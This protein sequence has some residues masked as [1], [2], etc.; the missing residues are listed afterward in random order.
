[1][2]TRQ[3]IVIGISIA[4]LGIGFGGKIFLASFKEEQ[5]K[6]PPRENIRSVE[7]VPVKYKELETELRA[8]GR[9][10]SAQP[11]DIMAEVAG[12]ILE[13]D[14]PLKKGQNFSQGTTL[15]RLDKEEASLNL[16]A[17]KSNFLRT[18]AGILP[19][20]KVDYAERLPVWQSYF[21]SLDVSKSFPEL[22]Q[23]QSAREKTFLASRGILSEF[24]SIRSAEERLSKYVI[25]APYTGSFTDVF[26]EKGSFANP[27]TRIAHIIRTDKL[28]LEAPI[29]S[30]DVQWVK[31]GTIVNVNSEDGKYQWQGLVSR[32]G[33]QVNP[34]TQS[35]NVFI[36]VAA[37]KEA[38]LYEGLYLEAVIPGKVLRKS[39]EIPRK[40]VMNRNQVFVVEG[41]RLVRKEI[42]VEKVNPTTIFFSGLDEGTQLVLDPPVNAMENM[43]VTIAA[44]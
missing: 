2:T 9:V 40:A 15:V 43:K 41:E 25:T 32:V 12:K 37:N 20:I 38:Q 39:M 44:K 10:G 18:L 6:T 29:R 3:F 36:T 30:E 35:V 8:F 4:L 28:E 22:P 11:V 24:Y 19:D 17:Q 26:L 13:G 1:M 16:L 5:K 27:G 21:E 42:V 14:V 31:K 7:A 23:G 34:A 33:S